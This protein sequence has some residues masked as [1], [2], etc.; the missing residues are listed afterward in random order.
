MLRCC[1]M[2][3]RKGSGRNSGTAD[4]GTAAGVG[5]TRAVDSAAPVGPT[6]SVE[7]AEGVRPT[8]AAAPVAPASAAAANDEIAAVAAALKSGALTVA[9]AVDRLIDDAVHKQVGR[10]VEPGSEIEARLRRLLRDQAGAD[11]LIREKIRRL[12]GRRSGR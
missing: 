7:S 6:D 2:A 11:P 8:S 5:G 3:Q 1:G 9:E 4:S 10:A 12:E